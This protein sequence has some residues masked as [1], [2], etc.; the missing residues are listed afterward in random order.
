M[1][2][3]YLINYRAKQKFFFLDLKVT[4]VY[5]QHLTKNFIDISNGMKPKQ[6]NVLVSNSWF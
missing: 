6:I 2:C 1:L 3:L 4:H 5:W